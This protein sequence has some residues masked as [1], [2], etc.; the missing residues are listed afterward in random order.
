MDIK[1]AKWIQESV[2]LTNTPIVFVRLPNTPI[3]DGTDA[4]QLAVAKVTPKTKVSKKD[5]RQIDGLCIL[6]KKWQKK[7]TFFNGAL[8]ICRHS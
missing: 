3:L 6:K 7:N 8:L 1:E 2:R 5:R 4:Q